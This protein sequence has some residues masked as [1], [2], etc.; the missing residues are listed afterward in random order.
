MIFHTLL[1]KA[2][3]PHKINKKW[4]HVEDSMVCLYILSKGRTSCQILQ[5]LCN[6]IGSI[7]LALGMT[8]MH[9]HMGSFEN[10]TD[11]TS[12]SNF[13]HLPRVL[14]AGRSQRERRH[15]RAGA[16]LRD[17]SVT[18]KT[19][20]RYESAVGI[21]LLFLERQSSLKDLNS[22]VSE[23]VELQ[24]AKGAP[25]AT[26]GDPLFADYLGNSGSCSNPGAG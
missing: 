21:L 16:R 1:W 4:L 25:L 26:I 15:R 14:P 6:R 3:S 22:I 7:Q 5:P 18:P 8:L 10:P 2:R 13:R 11:A 17:Y 12:R 9:A 20:A 24:W 23:R 19:K